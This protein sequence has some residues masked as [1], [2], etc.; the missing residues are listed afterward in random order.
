MMNGPYISLQK[1]ELDDIDFDGVKEIVDPWGLPL[2]YLHHRHYDDEP[3]RGKYRLSSIGP[4]G[5]PDTKDDRR[6]WD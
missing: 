3:G 6:N 4:D 1:R 5:R 2:R